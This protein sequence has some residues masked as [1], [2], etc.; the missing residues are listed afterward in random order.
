MEQEPLLL[1]ESMKRVVC[2]R[3]GEQHSLTREN[4]SD[5]SIRLNKVVGFVQCFCGD[6]LVT[7]EKILL[8]SSTWRNNASPKE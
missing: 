3:C 7:T 1:P 8:L 5:V 4:C 2:S 6:V